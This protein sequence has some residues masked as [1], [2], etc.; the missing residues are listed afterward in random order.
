MS[1]QAA[2]TLLEKLHRFSSTQLEP[3]ERVLLGVLLA[4][5][6]SSLLRPREVEGFTAT[7]IGDDDT[8]QVLADA[9]LGSTLRIVDELDDLDVAGWT[10]ELPGR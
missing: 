3:R 9:L 7:G 2:T 4:P 8:V 5:G 1:D 6:V 10:D